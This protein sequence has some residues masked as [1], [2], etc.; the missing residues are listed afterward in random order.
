MLLT[1]IIVALVA[2]LVLAILFKICNRV[3]Y[4][5]YI[6]MGIAAVTLT[7]I[8][9]ASWP[10]S[11]YET[12]PIKMACVFVYY[13]FAY[14]DIAL[15][16]TT[17]RNREYVE[18]EGQRYY[19]NEYYTTESNFWPLLGTGLA[20]GVGSWLLFELWLAGATGYNILGFV[21]IGTDIYLGIK[22]AIYII[23]RVQ[24]SR[25]GY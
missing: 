1:L 18:I 14:A 23:R 19:G 16:K 5:N 25:G 4:L 8:C 2:C 21:A 11:I 9:F 6:F 7:I 13:I 24:Y 12:A 22:L 15:D 17:Y 3:P 20:V 10:H